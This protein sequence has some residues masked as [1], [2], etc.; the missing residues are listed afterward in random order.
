MTEINSRRRDRQRQ[1][2]LPKTKVQRYVE[3]CP[4]LFHSDVINDEK[5]F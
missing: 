3:L 1:R 2:Q 5:Q 4:Q